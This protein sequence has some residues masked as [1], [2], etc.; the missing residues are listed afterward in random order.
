MLAISVASHAGIGLL[1]AMSLT[2]VEAYVALG[3]TFDG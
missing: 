1:D 2:I 3:C